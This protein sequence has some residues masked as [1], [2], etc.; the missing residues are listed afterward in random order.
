MALEGSL[1]DFGLADIL[2]LIYFQRKTGVLTL[3]GKMDGVTLFFID[4]NISGA[5]SRKRSETNRTGKILLKKGLISEDVL[6]SVLD[7]QH[8]TGSK[9]GNILAARRIVDA[10][11]LK[12][13]LSSQITETVVQLFSWKEGTYEFASRNVTKDKDLP[14]TIDTQHILMEGLR[15]VDEW[16]V[17]KDKISLD[18]VFRKK[19]EPPA[20]LTS[21]ER[22]LLAGIDGENDVSTIIDFSGKGHFEV[23][24]TLLS[25]MEKGVIEAETARLLQTEPVA[26]SKKMSFQLLNLLVPAAVAIAFVLAFAAPGLRSKTELVKEYEASAKIEDLRFRLET[27]RLEHSGLPATLDTITQEKDPWGLPFIYST[28]GDSF[29]VYSTGADGLSGTPDDIR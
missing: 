23:S 29:S 17:I 11:M 20:D 28:A 4:G 27:Y 22:D 5:E 7:E 19:G 24:K 16:A 13:I 3:E 2:Q 1:T 8:K 21:E 15:I 26:P 25:L 18:I 14:F 9:I 10:D 12:E 6:Q